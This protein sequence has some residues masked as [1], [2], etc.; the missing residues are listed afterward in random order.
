MKLSSILK[1]KGY[2]TDKKDRHIDYLKTYEELFHPLQS[3]NIKLLE[4]GV[5]K[6]ESLKLW[7][8]YFTGGKIYGIDDFSR[9][10]IRSVKNNLKEYKNVVSIDQVDSCKYEGD[11]I[12]I[13]D[14]YLSRFN[15]GFFDIII[16][17]GLHKS[18]FQ[19]A[20]YL[21]FKDKLKSNGLYI[22]EDIKNYEGH[23]ENL[24]NFFGDNITITHYPKTA[25]WDDNIIGV[26]N[27]TH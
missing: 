8:D 6:G 27:G 10:S 14:E 26:V 12:E 2:Q 15:D 21:N 1:S 11:I 7:S 19:I 22:I 16:D 13:R 25:G 18:E 17:D 23:M 20:T 9:T 3:K 4:I 5:F 24:Q